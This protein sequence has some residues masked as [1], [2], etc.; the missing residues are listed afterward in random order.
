[1]YVEADMVPGSKA[2]RTLR[3]L[4][5]K[6]N[7]NA[8]HDGYGV[9]HGSWH[10]EVF[11]TVP[12]WLDQRWELRLP[13]DMLLASPLHN[14]SRISIWNVSRSTSSFENT[15]I[16][17]SVRYTLTRLNLLDEAFVPKV[18]FSSRKLQ[19]SQLISRDS[20]QRRA[21]DRTSLP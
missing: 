6:G 18:V 14:G 5:I 11:G 17:L 10:F 1:M 3:K 4:S 12:K 7:D 13:R 2:F 8:F 21:I 15:A 16:D 19:D 9:M 20:H